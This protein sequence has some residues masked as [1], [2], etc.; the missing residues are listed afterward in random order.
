MQRKL[1]PRKRIPLRSPASHY[2]ISPRVS[3]GR[4]DDKKKHRHLEQSL[5]IQSVAKNLPGRTPICGEVCVAS[6]V[7]LQKVKFVYDK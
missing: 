5:V 7:F 6:E 2:G 1:H 3:L 4:N